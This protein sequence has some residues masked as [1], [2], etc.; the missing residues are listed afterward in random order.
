[1]SYSEH[2]RRW[3][4]LAS[5]VEEGYPLTLGDYANDLVLRDAIKEL[6]DA[7]SPAVREQ[8]LGELASIDHAFWA[9]TQPA[10]ES[11]W[12]NT[13]DPERWWWFRIPRVLL[14]DM[15]RDVAVYDALGRSD[16][17]NNS[18]P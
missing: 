18:D 1:M 16:G 11:A 3:S 17:A 15:A 13:T 6:L 14:E 10:R 8:R 12:L 9:A 4:R 5:E 2:V 7:S